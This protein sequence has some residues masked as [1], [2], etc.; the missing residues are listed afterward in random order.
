MNNK[1]DR[2]NAEGY[3]DP[4]AYGAFVNIEAEKRQARFRPIVYICSPYS[5]DVDAN[6]TNARRYSRFAV[7][8]G[9]LPITPHL[10]FPQFLNDA[11]PEER[12]M[13]MFMNMALLSKCA[14]L[15]VFGDD[16]SPGMKKE[17]ARAQYRQFPIRYFTTDCEEE[18]V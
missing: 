14:E 10:L 2:Y 12:D 18:S 9:Y 8:T 7:D 4:T 1:P 16:I 6:V 17:I 3:P 5:G 15:W 13:A 11:V